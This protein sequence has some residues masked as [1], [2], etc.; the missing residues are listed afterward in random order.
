MTIL[1]VGG[2]GV[3]ALLGVDAS[4]QL[5]PCWRGGKLRSSR[6]YSLGANLDVEEAVL[7]GEGL[8]SWPFSLLLEALGS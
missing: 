2:V 7:C 3:L 4:E 6:L 8:G 5:R 1:G